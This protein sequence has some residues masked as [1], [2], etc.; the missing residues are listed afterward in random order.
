MDTF[1]IKKLLDMARRRICWIIIPFF[2]IILGG[3]YYYLSTPRVYKATTLIMVQ[4]QK[5]PENYVQSIVSTNIQDRLRTITQQVTSRTNLEN[6]IQD[7][8]LYESLRWKGLLLEEKVELL[9]KQIQ[10]S[11]TSTSV[12]GDNAFSISFQYDDPNKVM[13][14]TNAL[15]SNFIS[16][17][18]K[19]R[20]DQAIGTSDF[21]NDEMESIKKQLME[22]EE[23][24][25]AYKERFMGGLPEQLATNLSILT[26]LRSQLEQL[27]NSLRSAEDRRA[28]LEQDTAIQ[29]RQST[30]PGSI[31]HDQNSSDTELT[32]LNNQ[33]I[34]LLAKYTENHPDVIRLKNKIAAIEESQDVYTTRE[35]S[36]SSSISSESKEVESTMNNNEKI[37]PQV[38]NVIQDISRLKE[39]IEQTKKKIDWYDTKV[40]ETPKREQELLS[41]NRD[42]SNLKDQYNNMYD[43]KLKADTAVNMEKKQKGEQFRVLDYAKVPVKPF[44]PVVWQLS[45]LTLAIGLG[46]GFGLAYII[47][48]SD[49]SYRGAAEIEKD[50]AI[51]VL[52]IMPNIYTQMEILREK[53]KKR[54]VA[55]SIAIGFIL[56]AI[57]I[58]VSVKGLDVAIGYVKSILEKI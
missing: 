55:A 35:I 12:S 45:L 4:A 13:R 34:S 17:N 3:V 23:Q 18:L 48:L 39:E 11:V 33:L 58:V 50:F 56:S 26:G 27:N 8:Q 31:S 46:A 42:Y 10:I 6:I 44:K 36:K 22:K 16:E 51:P 57:G 52:M 7:F 2:I 9:K 28:I 5:V 15:S 53:R 38:V 41:L 1:D 19:I 37:N 14:V 29:V 54:F 30:T 43:R 32:S 49:T 24:L 47:E 25:K 40:E 21:L 20:E